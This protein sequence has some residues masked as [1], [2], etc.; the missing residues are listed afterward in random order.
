MTNT[1][2]ST[3][4]LVLEGIQ[5][6]APTTV[7]NPNITFKVTNLEKFSQETFN[8]YGHIL[9]C[10]KKLGSQE[11][12]FFHSGWFKDTLGSALS[13][14]PI[15]GG[16]LRRLEDDGFDVMSNDCGVR[17]VEV[18]AHV[19]LDEFLCLK[20]GEA[21]SDLLHFKE[22]DE[23]NLHFSPLFYIQVTSF[24]CGGY[25]IG[26]S[27][28]LLLADPFLIES[29]LQRLA[30]IHKEAIFASDIPKKPLFYL[31]NIKRMG[32]PP[33]LITLT[34]SKDMSTNVVMFEV[35]IVGDPSSELCDSIALMCV[36]EAERKSGTQ[37][38]PGFTLL[39][40]QV[41]GELRVDVTSKTSLVSRAD[42]KSKYPMKYLGWDDLG[43]KGV[44][45]WKGNAPTLVSHYVGS[46]G[47]KGLV[48]LVISA[49]DEGKLGMKA[50]V[51]F[52]N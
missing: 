50:L 13:E 16:R 6:T 38:T 25:S 4:K 46:L 36:E 2:S 24:K 49:Q 43:T 45:F 27:Y 52:P 41:S 18:Q 37:M 35:A 22:V 17:I 14:N 3:P 8:K 1:N 19:D 20:R 29:F 47:H 32:N 12:G 34:T 28:N 42:D 33:E 30:E 7:T 23:E 31:P 40:K 5:T 39:V 21:R 10:Y 48:Y 26:I 44:A 15:L 9:L 51:A 11:S